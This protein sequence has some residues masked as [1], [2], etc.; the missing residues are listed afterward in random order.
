M[1]LADDLSGHSPTLASHCNVEDGQH[2]HHRVE[3]IAVSVNCAVNRIWAC[4]CQVSM[5]SRITC[6]VL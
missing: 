6:A 1:F 4:Y 2:W 5:W 3:S